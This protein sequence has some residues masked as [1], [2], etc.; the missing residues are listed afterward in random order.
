MRGAI[1]KWTVSIT[2]RVVSHIEVE[3][4][5]EAEA[6]QIGLDDFLQNGSGGNDAIEAREV[7]AY[8]AQS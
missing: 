1:V 3:A 7:Q 8:E 2:E 5:T 4:E 6:C